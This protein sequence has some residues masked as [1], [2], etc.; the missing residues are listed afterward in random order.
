MPSTHL[1]ILSNPDELSGQGVRSF[2]KWN[3]RK[4]VLPSDVVKV[5]ACKPTG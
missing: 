4:V 3:H 2:T 1:S 5:G